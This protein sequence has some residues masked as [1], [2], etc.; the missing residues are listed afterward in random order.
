MA[1]TAC[2]KT[3]SAHPSVAAT[4]DRELGNDS[5]NAH[6][7]GRLELDQGYKFQDAPTLSRRV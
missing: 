4:D 3:A 2:L 6:A 7:A 5:R 1:A